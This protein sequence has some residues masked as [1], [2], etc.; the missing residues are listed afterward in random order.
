MDEPV[1]AIDQERRAEILPYLETLTREYPIPLLY[2][3][4]ALDEVDR[5]AQQIVLLREG[6]VVSNE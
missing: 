2:V 1:A 4:H 5:L 3:S 6:Q